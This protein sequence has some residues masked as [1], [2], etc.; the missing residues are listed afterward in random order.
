MPSP[1]TAGS[2]GRCTRP[3]RLP[4]SPTATNDATSGPATSTRSA[5]IVP[6]SWTSPSIAKPNRSRRPHRADRGRPAAR[7][8]RPRPARRPPRRRPPA[9]PTSSR[10]TNYSPAPGRSR[11]TPASRR[12]G[13]SRRR[14][15][16]REVPARTIPAPPPKTMPSLSTFDGASMSS[17]VRSIGTVAARNWAADEMISSCSLD[18]RR[19][20]S[21]AGRARARP[22][23][24]AGCRSCRR[25]SCRRTTA[26]TGRSNALA[27]DR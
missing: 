9:P 19:S 18:G 10:G 5:S 14:Q 12:R 11:G 21:G 6:M 4:G 13:R 3:I 25:R 8:E 23:C 1:A 7:G 26:G 15:H 27:V 20:I 22:R 17:R 2:S 16:P 24:C